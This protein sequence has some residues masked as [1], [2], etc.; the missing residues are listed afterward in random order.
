M[1][2]AH[3]KPRR[4]RTE[5]FAA[6]HDGIRPLTELL[7]PFPGNRSGHPFG[8]TRFRRD[9]AIQSH[10]EFQNDKRSPALDPFEKGFIELSTAFLFDSG[11]DFDPAFPQN[12]RGG[13]GMTRIRIGT[14]DHDT[15]KTMINDRFCAWRGPPPCGARF[16]RNIKGRTFQT[17]SMRGMNGFDFRMRISHRL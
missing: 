12:S 13:S 1:R 5:S 6:N 14:A 7:H 16:K 2:I 8:I 15:R 9:P 3:G 4:I 11:N 10:R 17:A